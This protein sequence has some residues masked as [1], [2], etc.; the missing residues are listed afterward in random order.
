MPPLTGFLSYCYLLFYRLTTSNGVR[1]DMPNA[2]GFVY[3][4]MFLSSGMEMEYSINYLRNRFFIH[5]EKQEW[6]KTEG[7]EQHSAKQQKVR[8]L[9][10]QQLKDKRQAHYNRA[11]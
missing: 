2:N 7:K 3:H 9:K 5:T 8:P 11:Q 4:K 1:N 6:E 10:M